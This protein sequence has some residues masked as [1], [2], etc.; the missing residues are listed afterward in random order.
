MVLTP[1]P[2]VPHCCLLF[3]SSIRSWELH[4]QFRIAAEKYN[5]LWGRV[6]DSAE[7]CELFPLC[8]TE[9]VIKFRSLRY[10]G[11]KYMFL[12]QELCHLIKLLPYQHSH[13]VTPV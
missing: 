11:F 8:L 2:W 5:F 9:T 10:R 1:G 6:K 12:G 4:L 7:L 3:L 13:A